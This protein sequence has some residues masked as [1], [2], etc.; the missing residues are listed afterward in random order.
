MPSVPGQKAVANSRDAIASEF[1]QLLVSLAGQRGMWTL[2]DYTHT[3]TA[4]FTLT[5]HTD[6]TITDTNGVSSSTVTVQITGINDP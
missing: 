2:D 1:G 5:L 6:Q 3:T 4:V